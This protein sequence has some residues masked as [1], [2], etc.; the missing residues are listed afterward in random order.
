M[1]LRG[2]EKS[3]STLD[4]VNADIEKRI[5]NN[6][7]TRAKIEKVRSEMIEK[8]YWDPETDEHIGDMWSY[9]EK[10]RDII[11]K[12]QDWIY[13]L[14]ESEKKLK[15]LEQK[16]VRAEQQYQKDLM[17]QE[18]VAAIP[19]ILQDLKSAVADE[20][21]EN[22]INKQNR[23]KEAVAEDRAYYDEWRKEHPYQPMP[24]DRVREIDKLRK[25][26]GAATV[27]KLR[28]ATDKEV[29]R[30]ADSYAEGYVMNLI[31][32]V[33]KYVGTITDY[34]NLYLTGPAI[35]GIV[36]GER[37]RV[38][39]ETILAG[40]WNIQCLHNRVLVKRI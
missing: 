20:I 33:T 9:D 11:W 5:A 36:V 27:E 38:R 29:R 7:K 14:S 13:N 22:L 39:L 31:D 1:A 40:G 8:G 35:N 12:L 6:D 3:K 23:I 18:K 16:R 25:V 26:F 19:P 30:D 37:G 10:T 34:S 21:Y 28:Y 32:R 4:K 2:I 17:T 15:E 24:V